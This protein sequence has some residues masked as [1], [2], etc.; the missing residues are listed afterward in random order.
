M[1]VVNPVIALKKSPGGKL[2]HLW[3]QCCEAYQLYGN[4]QM[5]RWGSSDL[6]AEKY[7]LLQ[8]KKVEKKEK[9]GTPILQ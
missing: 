4:N 6:C 9:Y 1:N 3:T 5:Y 2:F 8:C 7:E